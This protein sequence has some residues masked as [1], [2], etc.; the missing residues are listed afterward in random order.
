MSLPASGPFYCSLH[1]S[2]SSTSSSKGDEVDVF[3][4]V[5]LGL[6]AEKMLF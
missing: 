3:L 5:L 1:Y 4:K 6:D 2:S